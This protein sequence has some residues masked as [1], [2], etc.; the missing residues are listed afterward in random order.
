MRRS[1]VVG[2]IDA[3]VVTAVQSAGELHSLVVSQD[4]HADF[5][6]LMQSQAVPPAV[7]QEGGRE[8][9][10]GSAPAETVELLGLLLL[11]GLSCRC[12]AWML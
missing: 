9:G 6:E 7:L 4:A 12:S 10:E 5:D 3:P 1:A 8:P 2:I 11:L